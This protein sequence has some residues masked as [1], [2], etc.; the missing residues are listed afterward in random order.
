M[1]NKY[2]QNSRSEFE[3]IK[4]PNELLEFMKNNIKYGFTTKD[5]K[6]YYDMDS[7][8]WDE[9]WYPECIVQSY[10]GI[11]DTLCGTC[12]DQVEL[13]REWFKRNKYRFKTIYLEFE[14]AGPEPNDYPTHS[15]LVFNENNKWFLF[16]NSFGSNRGIHEFNT[17]DSL[18][19]SVKNKLL[20][21]AINNCDLKLTNR[22]LINE[23]VYDKPPTNA[24]V[25][26]YINHVT[27]NK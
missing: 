10:E 19:V 16:E 15:F 3:N 5:G 27:S 22:D 20:E 2:S 4:T 26:E 7:K 6:K 9:H 23:W 17:L 18:I 12:W 25:D 11:L 13:E 14:T 21:H 24:S 1:T 8:E